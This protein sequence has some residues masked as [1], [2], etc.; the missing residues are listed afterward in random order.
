M[1]RTGR[2]GSGD[3]MVLRQTVHMGSEGELLLMQMG[4]INLGEQGR[5]SLGRRRSGEDRPRRYGDRPHP[6]DGQEASYEEGWQEFG[7]LVQSRESEIR[8]AQ[9]HHARGPYA[10]SGCVQP[11]HLFGGASGQ[12]RCHCDCHGYGADDG[13]YEVT[14]TFTSRRRCILC[15]LQ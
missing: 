8:R 13:W 12:A 5:P 11:Q 1:S 10:S 2:M 9:H 6:Y 4:R 14:I 7:P 15:N 3:E